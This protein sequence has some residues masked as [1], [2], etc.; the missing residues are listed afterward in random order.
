VK[1]GTKLY[2]VLKHKCPRCHEGEMFLKTGEKNYNIIGYTP[3]NCKVCGQ[4]FVLEPGF[5]YGAMYLSYM[6]SVFIALPQFIIYYAGFNMSFR[7][8]LVFI[9]LAQIVLTPFIYKTS[10][11]IWINVFV[12]YDSSFE[13][14]KPKL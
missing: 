14:Q 6:L 12:S 9:V 10:R 13:I 1:K 3:D 2:S 5:Y 8:S 4:V 11:T 7:T